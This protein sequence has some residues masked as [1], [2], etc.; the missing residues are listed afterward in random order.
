MQSVAGNQQPTLPQAVL[1]RQRA[2]GEEL[3]RSITGG[4]LSASLAV[5]VSSSSKLQTHNRR[6]QCLPKRL[7]LQRPSPKEN[8]R[9]Y[10]QPCSSTAPRALW[11]STCQ[12]SV[13]RQPTA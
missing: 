12:S 11:V 7:P 3:L 10:C 4:V 8:S 13:G 6:L 5:E 9:A 1:P 2:R